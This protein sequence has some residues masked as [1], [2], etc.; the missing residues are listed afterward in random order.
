MKFPEERKKKKKKK[1]KGTK[2][3]RKEQKESRIDGQEKE[4]REKRKGKNSIATM[5]IS[6]MRARDNVA[7]VSLSLKDREF[8]TRASCGGGLFTH[9]GARV[10]CNAGREKRREGK[11]KDPYR[12]DACR[13]PRNRKANYSNREIER[14]R[15]REREKERKV[16]QSSAMTSKDTSLCQGV[17]FPRLDLLCPVVVLPVTQFSDTV[18]VRAHIQRRGSLRIFRRGCDASTIFDDGD[19]T[20]AGG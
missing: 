17:R 13:F 19:E 14:E 10:Q 15:E 4:K 16:R 5:K 3:R 11:D 9:V 12:V 6:Q 20:R 18:S 8:R 7:V 1:K 2:T